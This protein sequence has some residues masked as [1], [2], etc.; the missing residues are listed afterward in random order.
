MIPLDN[1]SDIAGPIARSVEDVARML[2]VLVGVDPNDP[3]TSLSKFLKAPANY[4]SGLSK[5]ALKVHP[6]TCQTCGHQ[7]L[8]ITILS[9]RHESLHCGMCHSH[10]VAGL[11]GWRSLQGA[12]IGVMRQTITPNTS[13]P[14]VMTL[15]G[16]ALSTLQQQGEQ[17]ILQQAVWHWQPS[18]LNRF[19]QEPPILFGEF[20]RH[21]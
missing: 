18:P 7:Q 20:R 5:G 10:P 2:E 16:N 6:S 9:V 14:D 15:F 13:D 11:R 21:L 17:H 3:L 12:R 1:T 8:D 4:S 19:K